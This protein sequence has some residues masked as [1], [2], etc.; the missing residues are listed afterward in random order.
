VKRRASAI[1][2]ASSPGTVNHHERRRQVVQQRIAGAAELEDDAVG[3]AGSSQP[4][5]VAESFFATLKN[6]LI[7][8][9]AWPTRQSARSA[10]F[11]FMRAGT[12]G[13]ASIHE[14]DYCR[15]N[16]AA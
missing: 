3:V 2:L 13:S 8:L 12:T 7:Y 11:T 9:H 15:L 10:V 5:T 6:E 1:A 4:G 14:E 16:N